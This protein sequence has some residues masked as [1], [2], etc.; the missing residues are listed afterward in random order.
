MID[1]AVSIGTC[2]DIPNAKPIKSY[3]ADDIPLVVTMN[4]IAVLKTPHYPLTYLS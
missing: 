3:M 4:S 1:G 2:L